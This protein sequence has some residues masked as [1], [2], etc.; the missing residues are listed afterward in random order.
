MPSL[1]SGEAYGDGLCLSS[2]DADVRRRTVD[3]LVGYLEAAQGLGAILVVGLLQ[4]LRRDEPD[5]AAARARIADGLR[6]V[7][8]EAEG[9]QVDVVLE[10]VNH[11]QVG[12][13]NSVAEVLDL[14]DAIG[15]KAVKPMVDTIH[16][17]I[18]EASLVE[19]IRRCGARLRHVHLCESHGAAFG[20]GHIDFAAVL[21]VLDEIGYD[22]YASVKVY[23][24]IPFDEA[25]PSS[26]AHLRGCRR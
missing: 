17:N 2:A 12:F 10:P 1:L 22:R 16:M 9:R 15:S 14:I 19:P 25:A 21:R 7:A 5:V 11:L 20:A 24:G 6:R 23:R 8:A 3:R 13:H 18:E 4:G 26:L